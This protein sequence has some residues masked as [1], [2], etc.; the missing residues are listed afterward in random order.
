MAR[1]RR[2]FVSS[3][4]CYRQRNFVDAT[5]LNE[6]RNFVSIPVFYFH[7]VTNGRDCNVGYSDADL[8]FSLSLSVFFHLF[9]SC[10]NKF[11]VCQLQEI[12][13]SK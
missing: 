9:G 6:I 13:G 10:F 7:C 5:R 4:C 11:F 1:L 8:S 2:L 12:M 3:A